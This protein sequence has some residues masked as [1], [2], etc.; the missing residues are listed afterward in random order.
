MIVEVTF[1]PQGSNDS[2][3]CC[4]GDAFQIAAKRVHVLVTR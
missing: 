3:R 1:D 4:I 2:D